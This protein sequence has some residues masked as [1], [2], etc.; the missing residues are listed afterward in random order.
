MVTHDAYFA[1]AVGYTRYWQVHDGFL[2]P[3]DSSAI[4]S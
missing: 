4:L 1:S 2:R 3:D